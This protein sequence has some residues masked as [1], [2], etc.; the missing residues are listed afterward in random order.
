MSPLQW[1]LL[2]LAA[3]AVIAIYLF[4]RR[5]RRALDSRHRDDAPEEPLLPPGRA[6]QLDIFGNAE[7][8]SGQ[9]DEYGVSRPRRVEPHL[10]G[11]DDEPVAP[12]H[13]PMPPLAARKPTAAKAPGQKIVSLLIAE[14]SGGQIL[15]PELHAALAAQGLQYGAKQIYHRLHGS[16]IVFSVASLLK[17]GYLDPDA[18]ETFSTLGLTIFM[19][20]PGPVKAADAVRDMIGCAEHLAEALNAEVYDSHRQI[21]TPSSARSLQLEVENWARFN[22]PI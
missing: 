12:L 4:S 13:A 7:A 15:G 16:D 18:A 6:R 2:I 11:S 9:F 21:F 3:L 19:V 17:P 5:D 14:R 20:L 8:A 10:D 22:I 1:A